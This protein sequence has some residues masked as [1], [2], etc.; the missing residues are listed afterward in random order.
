MELVTG[1]VAGSVARIPSVPVWH[2]DDVFFCQSVT[3][4]LAW[5]I[6]P[7]QSASCCAVM[8][9]EGRGGASKPRPL[10]TLILKY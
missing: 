2:R 1:S 10:V 9:R 5:A 4:G 7:G 8:L 6:L 3:P